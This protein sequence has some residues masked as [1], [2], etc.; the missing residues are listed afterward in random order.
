MI[1]ESADAFKFEGIALFLFLPV[2][3]DSCNVYLIP[4]ATF[5]SANR[6]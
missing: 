4:V 1:V 2:L 6:C 3:T 5:S